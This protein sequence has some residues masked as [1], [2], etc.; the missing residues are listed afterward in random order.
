MTSY[1]QASTHPSPLTHSLLN[2]SSLLAQ[3]L[4]P[5]IQ[6]QERV[7]LLARAFHLLHAW[8]QQ[9]AL[10]L[11]GLLPGGAQAPSVGRALLGKEL[12][13]Q[14]NW[15]ELRSIQC[16]E[17]LVMLDS[18]EKNKQKVVREE[19]L[20]MLVDCFMLEDVICCQKLEAEITEGEQE[21]KKFKRQV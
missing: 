14:C 16:S 11:L 15:A 6:Y 20:E 21:V 5:H 10:L 17:G 13:L 12:D 3:S 1:V 19:E 9:H 7:G 4:F 8:P 2:I 18:L